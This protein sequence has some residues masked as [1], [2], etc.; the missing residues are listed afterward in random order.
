MYLTALSIGVVLFPLA[1]STTISFG[2]GLAVVC[3][4]AAGFANT[5]TTA[6]ANTLVQTTASDDLRG[7]VMSVYSTVLAGTIPIGALIAG[8]IADF[9]GTPAS[10]AF[11]GLIVVGG[12]LLLAA[13]ARRTT[14]TVPP[15]AT[16]VSAAGAVSTAPTRLTTSS[17][18]TKN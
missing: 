8:A 3:L 6:T 5:T 12:V 7:R 9:A 10:V 13:Q 2:I 11:G 18:R 1:L 4:A 17:L 14:A 16:D 15:P